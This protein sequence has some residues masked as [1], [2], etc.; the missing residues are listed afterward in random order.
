MKPEGMANVSERIRA[1]ITR[2]EKA[3]K[4]P[5]PTPIKVGDTVRNL[6]SGE[7]GYVEKSRFGVKVTGTNEDGMYWMTNGYSPEYVTRYWEVVGE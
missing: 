1:V 7:L 3:T 6:V 2:N 5:E 4:R